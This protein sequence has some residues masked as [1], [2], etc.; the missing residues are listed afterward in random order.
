MW[1]L[2]HTMGLR[3]AVFTSLG[4][5]LDF[6]RY[7]LYPLAMPIIDGKAL[8]SRLEQQT[9][10][11]LNDTQLSPTL[12]ILQVGEDAASSIYIRNK[13]AAAERIGA[14]A[15]LERV[16]ANTS[17]I[18]LKAIIQKWND[19]SMV[20]GILVQLPLKGEH[21]TD[22]II[23]TI[24]PQ[25]DVDAFH[26]ENAARLAA[27]NPLVISPVHEAVLRLL[28]ETP[29]KLAGAITV[30]V[31]NTDTFANPL[32]QLLKTAGSIVSI[33]RPDELDSFKLKEADIIVIAIGRAKFIHPSMT[34]AKAIVI[35]IGIN[36]EDGKTVGDADT[37]AFLD[38][39][40]HITPVPGG[41]GPV[42]VAL[43]LN[44]LVTLAI[45]QKAA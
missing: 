33:N 31:T 3:I 2:G 8:A 26:P 10:E 22:G 43:A 30:L 25:K 15:I 9:K 42:T 13:M 34:S 37:Q 32:S 6:A 35:D 29:I 40:H 20:N 24:S 11:R 36:K 39:G 44:N 27:S 19:N 12:A 17:D 38:A 28:A 14:K 1:S 23:Q 21:D 4:Q 16:D 41:V 45:A 5:T 7:K 18:D